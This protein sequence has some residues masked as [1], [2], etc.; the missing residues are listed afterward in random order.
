MRHEI[1]KEDDVTKLSHKWDQDSGHKP[2]ITRI[3]DLPDLE[4]LNAATIEWIAEGLFA[5]GAL[6]MITSESGAGKSTFVSAAAYAI[7][8]GKV[9]MGRPTKNRPVLILDAENPLT[10]VYERFKR[11]GIMT[12]ENFYVWGQW[13][14]DGPPDVGGAI[15]QEWVMR[16][17]P[18]PV[19]IVDTVIAFLSG[20]E[21]DSNDTR[22]HMAQYRALTALGATV[23][24]LHHTG[25][26]ETSKEYRG[27]S[28]Y[29]ASI[30][31]GYLL[32]NLGDGARLAI[33]ELRPFKQRFSVQPVLRILY[34]DGTFSIKHGEVR[35]SVTEELIELLKANPGVT[36][37]KFEGIAAARNLGRSSVRDF[38]KRGVAGGTVR[39]EIGSK[40]SQR[41]FWVEKP[42]DE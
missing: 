20:A 24:L 19:I 22:K 10:V 5:E 8:L 16:C 3:E 38:L 1:E 41:H 12:H 7:S 42:L 25:K 32:T 4:S 9:F 27:S 29:K 30:D 6:T 13:I 37:G 15:I 11:L 40:N 14:G 18:K 33:L 28:D 23:I 34:D 2:A 35:K 39:V 36:T 31:I 26:S 21:N 17:N